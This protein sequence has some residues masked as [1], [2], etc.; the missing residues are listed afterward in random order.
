MVTSPS[1]NGSR[2][3][4]TNHLHISLLRLC[5]SR[6]HFQQVA[7]QLQQE[8]QQQSEAQ[9]SGTDDWSGSAVKLQPDNKLLRVQLQSGER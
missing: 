9:L 5:N 4:R 1:S 6:R 3:S 8:Q 2:S 7:S